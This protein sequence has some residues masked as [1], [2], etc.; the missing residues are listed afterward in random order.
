MSICE[1]IYIDM[2]E[3]ICSLC[4]KKWRHTVRYKP[5]ESDLEKPTFGL[6]EAELITA[7]GGCRSLLQKR[8]EL[9]EE[10]DN[11]EWLIFDKKFREN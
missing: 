9:K 6:K 7:H 5:C 1:S 2:R 3:D 11:I 4:S 8:K 10:L